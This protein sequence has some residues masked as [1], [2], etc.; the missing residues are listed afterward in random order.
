MREERKPSF[1]TVIARKLMFMKH[2]NKSLSR[3]FPTVVMVSNYGQSI[4]T[5]TDEESDK[6][7]KITSDRKYLKLSILHKRHHL[8]SM[9]SISIIEAI[10]WNIKF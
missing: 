4:L 2:R 1:R 6:R 7:V 5:G 3:L 9:L 10:N 8:S